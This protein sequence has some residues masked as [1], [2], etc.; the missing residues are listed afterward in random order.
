[1]IQPNQTS[2][3]KWI[4]ESNILDLRNPV[5]GIYSTWF[6]TLC[7]YVD[8][9]G[10][11]LYNYQTLVSAWR[12]YVDYGRRDSNSHAFLQRYLKPPCIPIS[13]HPLDTYGHIILIITNVCWLVHFMWI[14][15][16]RYQALRVYRKFWVVILVT[17]LYEAYLV[18]LI[19]R[20]H[21]DIS[22][23]YR[24]YINMKLTEYYFI[25]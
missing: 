25:H 19:I 16:R 14:V 8:T 22:S 12:C 11:E 3:N 9:H 4:S 5:K 2:Y 20:L 6:S 23:R 15:Y 24:R 1:M 10:C 21:V 7:G 13:P 18:H 17:P